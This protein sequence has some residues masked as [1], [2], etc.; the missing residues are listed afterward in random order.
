LKTSSYMKL[1]FVKS[2]DSFKHNKYD[3][4][5]ELILLVK[6]CQQYLNKNA[7]DDI[8]QIIRDYDI[9]WDKF[10]EYAKQHSILPLL[11]VTFNTKVEGIPMKFRQKVR[12][13][14]QKVTKRNNA[15]Y[16]EMKRVK[17][18]FDEANINITPYKGLPMC[19]QFYNDIFQRLS[20]DI[21]FAIKLDEY[22]KCKP[23]ME[24]LGY[25]EAKGDLD[26]QSV[27]KSRAYYLDYPWTLEK[28]GQPLFNTE[29]HWT[30]SHNILNIPITFD[31]FKNHNATVKTGFYSIAT[32]DKVY[33]AL[34]AIIHHGSVDCW[35]KLKHLVDLGQIL[36]QLDD[37][38][39]EELTALCKK[40]K[41]LKSFEVGKK[42]LSEVLSYEIKT[43]QKLPQRWV[44]DMLS[45]SI[46][47]SKWTD[48]RM[49][50]YFFIISRDSFWDKIKSLK[51]IIHYQL[52]IKPKLNL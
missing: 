13:V 22:P 39:L 9:D 30:P 31:D 18:A 6:Y 15:V 43:K 12:I 50:L 27:E 49:K 47:S 16:L 17:K 45:G 4:D 23:I 41:I 21:D 10:Y 11:R 52:F 37:T 40:F 35:G 51:S 25:T 29:F 19:A 26:D 3:C 48:N 1:D 34:I 46:A 33:Q 32:F 14:I 42:F 2:Q 20:V 38:E 8:N 5:V 7:I 36:N 24:Q 44:Q 28:D